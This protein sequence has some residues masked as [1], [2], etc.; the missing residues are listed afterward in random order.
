MNT[1]GNIAEI[2]MGD[3]KAIFEVVDGVWILRSTWKR[4]DDSGP[5]DKVIVPDNRP[6]SGKYHKIQT[7]KETVI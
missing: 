7:K 1:N 2:T 5:F 4:A 3:Y 6:S